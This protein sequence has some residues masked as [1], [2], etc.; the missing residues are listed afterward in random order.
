MPGASLYIAARRW[1]RGAQG[2]LHRCWTRPAADGV[3][4]LRL[5]CG[6][7]ERTAVSGRRGRRTALSQNSTIP[8][9]AGLCVPVA[10]GFAAR[11]MVPVWRTVG[12]SEDAVTW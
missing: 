1:E 7:S 2:W 12:G 5:L 6:G 10:Q 9:A 4:S 11:Y 8:R 3:S